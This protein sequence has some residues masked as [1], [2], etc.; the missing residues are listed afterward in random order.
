MKQKVSLVLSGGGA[1]GIAHI[2][3]IEELEKRGFEIISVSGTSMGSLVGGIYALGKMGEFKD[4]AL[5]LDK[6]KIFGM[7]DFTFSSQGFIKGDKVLTKMKD[8]IPDADI[9]NLRIPYA[10]VAAD[11]INRKEVVFTQGSVYNAIRASIAIP[12]F[13]TPVKT[14]NG[15]LVDGGVLN[16][17]PVSHAKR[18]RGDILV[19]VNVNA[20]VPAIELPGSKKEKEA[21][22]SGHKAKMAEFYHQIRKTNSTDKEEKFGYI[23]LLNK[24]ISLMISGTSQLSLEKYPPDVMINISRDSCSTYDFFKVEEM[25]EIGRIVASQTLDDW[26]LNQQQRFIKAITGFFKVEKKQL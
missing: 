16:N 23:N 11:I 25:I 22:A 3:V 9:E 13:F 14:E 10:A 4:W 26:S 6:K 24:T 12:T 5:S 2:G 1:R 19:V 15:L 17:I 21:R 20:N 7:V 18:I 8:F